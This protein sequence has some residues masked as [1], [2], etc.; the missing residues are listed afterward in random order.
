M[1]CSLHAP[2]FEIVA[3]RIKITKKVFYLIERSVLNVWNN[4][5]NCDGWFSTKWLAFCVLIEMIMKQP[6]TSKKTNN[7]VVR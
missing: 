5:L 1:T 4:V 6:S 7:G 2:N 3:Q